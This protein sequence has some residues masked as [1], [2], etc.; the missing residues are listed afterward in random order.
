[1][2]E[3]TCVHYVVGFSKLPEG[4]LPLEVSGLIRILSGLGIKSVSH[5]GISAWT[6]LIPRAE[7][8]GPQSESNLQDLEWLTPRV[9]A[10]EKIAS[11]L[12]MS[13]TFYPCRFGVLFSDRALINDF[14]ALN[15]SSLEEYFQQIANQE[16]YGLKIYLNEEIA[17]AQCRKD[18]QNVGNSNSETN[19]NYLKERLLDKQAKAKVALLVTE[20]MDYFDQHLHYISSEFCHRRISSLHQSADQRQLIASMAILVAR[21]KKP[22]LASFIEEANKKFGNEQHIQCELTGP[23]PCYSFCPQLQSA[24]ASSQAA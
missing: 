1:M 3:S 24:K 5:Q 10:H 14:I 13:T 9:L 16:E 2:N 21:S 11:V 23:W 8:D 17:V 4:K 15:L 7:L 18:L 19:S 20:C 22:E 12:S 6:K